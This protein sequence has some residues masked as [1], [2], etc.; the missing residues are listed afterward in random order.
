MQLTGGWDYSISATNLIFLQL[1]QPIKYIPVKAQER[2]FSGR[3]SIDFLGHQKQDMVRKELKLKEQEFFT[4]LTPYSKPKW[5][6]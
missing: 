5:V 1:F 6:M 3:Y 4:I 2:N